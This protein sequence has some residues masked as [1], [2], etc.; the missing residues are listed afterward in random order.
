ME[1][2]SNQESYKGSDWN[3]IEETKT[4]PSPVNL[5]ILKYLTII[6]IRDHY[7]QWYI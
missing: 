6:K 1:K 2:F 5:L 4:T 3:S 7:T